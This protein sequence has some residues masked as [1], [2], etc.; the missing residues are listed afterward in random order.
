MK[1]IPKV[2]LNSATPMTPIEMNAVHFG[3][4]H[5]PLTPEQIKSMASPQ[6]KDNK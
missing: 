3:G 5:T 2:K 1:K 4:I 6:P